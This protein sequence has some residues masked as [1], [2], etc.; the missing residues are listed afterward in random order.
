MEMSE[1]AAVAKV[2]EILNPQFLGD[3]RASL[4]RLFQGFRAHEQFREFLYNPFPAL[5]RVGVPGVEQ[6]PGETREFVTET[7]RRSDIPYPWDDRWKHDPNAV[8]KALGRAICMMFFI[9]AITVFL[10]AIGVVVALMIKVAAGFV[11]ALGAA[12]ATIGVFL[13]GLTVAQITQL[14]TGLVAVGAVIGALV[15]AASYAVCQYIVT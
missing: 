13:T 12:L 15:I 6:L 2:N 3:L 11:T 10:V 1:D 7:I 4:D 14:L 9:L 5:A 8:K